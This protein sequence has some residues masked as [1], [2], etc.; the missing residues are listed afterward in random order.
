MSDLKPC[1]FCGNTPYKS[2]V[3]YEKNGDARVWC[4]QCGA[5]GPN[6]ETTEECFAAWNTRASADGGQEKMREAL[7]SLREDAIE[8]GALTPLE[9][10]GFVDLVYQTCAAALSSPASGAEAKEG[11]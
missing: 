8:L 10:G 11:E 6:R 7:E 2:E 3:H 5:K 9:K 4:D 1:A